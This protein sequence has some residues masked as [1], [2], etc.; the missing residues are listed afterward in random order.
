MEPEDQAAIQ[1]DLK[2]PAHIDRLAHQALDKSGTFGIET[3]YH[4]TRHDP[5]RFSTFTPAQ[6][7]SAVDHLVTLG[8][9]ALVRTAQQHAP[10]PDS[11]TR[12]QQP[13][14]SV[15]TRSLAI[16]K[17]CVLHARLRL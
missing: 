13:Y 1:Q 15:P 17:G 10:I 5:L 11:V 3:S 16:V 9:Q 2:E 6:Q 7:R 4:W 8:E 12:S 14:I